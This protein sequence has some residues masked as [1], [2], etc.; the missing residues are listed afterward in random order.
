MRRP[1]A[2]R[3]CMLSLI[4]LNI[5]AGFSGPASAQSP[6]ASGDS[7][8]SAS[9]APPTQL[10]LDWLIQEALSRNPEIRAE[11]REVDARRARVPQAGALPDPIVTFGQSNEGNIVPFTTLGKFDFSEVYLG[12]TQEFPLF[13]K[14]GL[15][16]Q[17]A[18]SEADAQWWE[19]D[20]AR[21]QVIANLKAAY[22]DL[23]YSHKAMEI[24]EK[25]IGL[26]ESYAKIAEA[27]YKVGKGNQADVLRAN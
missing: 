12:F 21:R 19:Y 22:Y 5:V 4:M 16:E 24:V 14:R 13:G 10:T 15:R 26:M 6:A 18:S 1:Q 3:L 23:H 27:L 25:N 17:V 7:I 8:S 20:F 11:M 2:K 9:Q